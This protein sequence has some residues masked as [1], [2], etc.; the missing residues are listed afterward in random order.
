MLGL[1]IACDS[2]RL[3]VPCTC[4]PGFGESRVDRCGSH[5]CVT[6]GEHPSTVWVTQVQPVQFLLS[7]GSWRL[8]ALKCL[9]RLKKPEKKPE[10]SRKSVPATTGTDFASATRG[11]KE[12]VLRVPHIWTAAALNPKPAPVRPAKGGACPQFRASAVTMPTSWSTLMLRNIRHIP[13]AAPTRR[14]LRRQ[15]QASAHLDE[16]HQLVS[17]GVARE[18]RLLQCSRNWTG[19]KGLQTLSAT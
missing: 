3:G 5:C 16:P 2:S 17:A 9:L 13:V 19:S 15:K 7:G 11:R 8:W 6:A 1:H 12:C 18:R 14:E 4:W 10:K